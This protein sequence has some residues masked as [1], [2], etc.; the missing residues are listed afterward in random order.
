MA[1]QVVMP[2]LGLTM[3]RGAVVKWYKAEG[4]AVKEGDLLAQIETDKITNDI[5]SPISGVLVKILVAEGQ[6]AEV[7]STIAII[8]SEGEF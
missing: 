3:E 6:E 5:E 2:K 4:E 7:L 1:T 8:G